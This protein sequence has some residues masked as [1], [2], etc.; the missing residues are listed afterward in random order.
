V[1]TT[2]ALTSGPTFRDFHSQASIN[3]S[4]T[5]AFFATLDG[6]GETGMFTSV[7][8]PAN[9]IAKFP[10]PPSSFSPAPSIN[11]AGNVAFHATGAS[12]TVDRFIFTGFGFGGNTTELASTTGPTFNTL[13]QRPF[14]NGGGTVVFHATLDAGGDGIFASAGGVT[15]VIAQ[16]S[17][18]TFSGF[19]T[20]GPSINDAG[21]VVFYAGTDAGDSGIF[22]VSNG[23]TRAIALSSGIYK[24]FPYR[25]AINSGGT[26]AFMAFLDS[27]PTGIYLANGTAHT[28][29]VSV[30]DALF[31]STVSALNFGEGTRGL[32]DADQIAF[33]Y[34]LANGTAGIAV[35]T[36]PEPTA[37]LL[38]SVG[39]LALLGRHRTSTR[40]NG[41]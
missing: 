4:G 2:I 3:D 20:G 24:G 10:S 5:V 34:T 41:G 21:T 16:S 17:G 14:I 18:P 23:V 29:V 22:T 37:A 30:G 35:A 19:S 13:D 12:N 39:A 33:N 28:R 7:G 25:A 9:T 38:L 15:S 8:G 6:T 1:T 31:G 36:V 27:G 11:Q 32:N 26:V 40:G